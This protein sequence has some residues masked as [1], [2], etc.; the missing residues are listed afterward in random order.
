MRVIALTLVKFGIGGHFSRFS[1]LMTLKEVTKVI[2]ALVVLAY[3][4]LK[5]SAKKKILDYFLLVFFTITVFCL[6]LI[7]SIRLFFTAF[8]QL[9]IR[10]FYVIKVLYL[11]F[12]C[13]PELGCLVS[14]LSVP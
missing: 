3:G 9:F 2:V 14:L 11:G 4:L 5:D 13:C 10:L 12:V 8:G 7:I 1:E 6:C